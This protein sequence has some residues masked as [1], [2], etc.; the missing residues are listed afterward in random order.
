MAV[1]HSAKEFVNGMAHTNGIESFWANMKRGY[2]GIYHNW[3]PK[4]TARYVAE[5]AGRHNVRPLDTEEQMSAIM[6]NAEGRQL[7][8][9]YLV[10]L[11]HT[12]L[13]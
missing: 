8:Y 5:F 13:T 2:Q 7:S 12:R 9:V 11:K 6:S 4:H 1:K 3:S 10:G